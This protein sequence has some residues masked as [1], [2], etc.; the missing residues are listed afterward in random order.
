[1]SGSQRFLFGLIM[2]L[3]V[4]GATSVVTADKFQIRTMLI[5]ALGCNVAWGIIDAG[6]YLMARLAERGR[7]AL[8]L[9]KVRETADRESAHRIIADALPPLFTSIAQPAQLEL[10]REGFLRVV[11]SEARPRLIGRDWL[12]ALSVCILV[13]LSTFPVV[14][15][16]II[17]E[18]AQSALRISNAIAVVSLFFCGFVFARHAGLQPWSTGLIMVARRGRTGGHCDSPRRVKARQGT[19]PNGPGNADRPRGRGD[20]TGG[21]MSAFDTKRTPTLL[22]PGFY[23]N[24]IVNPLRLSE[25]SNPTCRPCNCRT[26]PFEF[27]NVTAFA[28]AAT[29]TPAEMAEYVPAMSAAVR[30][31][32][33]VPTKSAPATPMVPALTPPMLSR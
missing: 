22:S 17:F 12:G 25:A 1:M 6:M 5:A 31:L 32:E 16:F 11:D 30:R 7:N 24:D 26:T 8:L 18:N 19:R 10:I 21:A 13:I 4:T 27:C 15:P 14:I 9:R 3:T 28:P 29:A 20:R 23:C 33:A 2:A